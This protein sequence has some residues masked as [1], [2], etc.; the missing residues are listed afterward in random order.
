MKYT[1][2]SKG[3]SKSRESILR[4]DTVRTLIVLSMVVL[5]ST[6][7]VAT[8]TIGTQAQ[9]ATGGDPDLEAYAPEPTL[10]PGNTETLT[11]QIA[12]DA[13]TRYDTP[14]ERNRVT[15]ARNVVVEL[16]SSSA[17]L[18]VETAEHSVGSISEN[19]PRSVPFTVDIPE[20][21]EPGTYEVDVEMTYSYTSFRRS[22]G[23]EN[24]RT[25]T[26]TDTVEIEIDDAPQFRLTTVDDSGLQIGESG[27]L[28]I[29]IENIGG[30][31]ARNVALSLSSQSSMVGFNGQQ[32]DVGR[33]DTLAP[34]EAAEITYETAVKSDASV[35]QYELDGTVQYT[36][37]DGIDGRDTDL[38]TGIE[39]A[40]EQGFSL[41]IVDGTVRVDEE[42]TIQVRVT[43]EGPRTA[44][45]VAL[46]F[47]R[48]YPTLRLLVGSVSAGTLEQG[49]SATVR[50]PIAATRDAE[51]VEKSLDMRVQY[52]TDADEQRYDNDVSLV[53]AIAPRRDDFRVAASNA[54]IGVDSSRLIKIEVT[55]NRN[56][57]LTN[58]E[59]SLGT[60]D[61][62][63]SDDDD[64]YIESLDPGESTT[65]VFE[66][67]ATS[68][69][70][71]KGYAASI[72]FRYD[73]ERGKSMMSETYQIPV[74]VEENDG[75]GVFSILPLVGVGLVGAGVTVYVRRQ[76]D[77]LPWSA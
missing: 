59:A 3:Q 46:D 19:E 48:E 36:N 75:L 35:R 7:G 37:P 76:G 56:Q 17:P 23:G 20:D 18:T 64:G 51:A 52:R 12:N 54:T 55:N 49:E 73:D 1:D 28:T 66:L 15:T 14:P 69:A 39:P 13:T 16:D 61:P 47:A 27:P 45:D 34:G 6:A 53:T 22:G 70:N 25:Y 42:T 44:N 9:S 2:G 38:S 62:L 58:I 50:L 21:A 71:P 43:N 72:D 10:T 68:D 65:L 40:A 24:E 4:S 31:P 26:V 11:I 60:S 5:L 8:T 74:Q 67:S 33:V 41:D 30:E 57:T 77:G 29:Q 32:S 63:D